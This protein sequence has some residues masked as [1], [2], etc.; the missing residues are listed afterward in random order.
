MLQQTTV[1]AVIPYFERFLAR[2]PDVVS[3]AAAEQHEVLA[4]WAGLG[5]YAR[6]RNL[7]ACARIVAALGGFPADIAGLRA[8]PGIG[9]YTASAVA[10]I[11]FG[12]PT[13]PVDG[14]VERVTARLFAV[15]EPLPGARPTLARLAATLGEDTDARAAPSDFAQ[16]LFDLGATICTPRRPTCALC[17]WREPCAG[18]RGGI[19]E[20]LPLKAAKMERP[21]RHGVHFWLEDRHGRVLLR[22]RPATGLFAGMTE[23]PGTAWR[24]EPWSEADALAAAPMPAPWRRVGAVLHT[25]T[26]LEVRL[27]LFAANVTAIEAEG[28]LRSATALEGEALPTIM[29]KCVAMAVARDE[30]C[31]NSGGGGSFL[32]PDAEGPQP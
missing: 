23:L 4:L 29:R 27:E 6:G 22:R 14:N 1:T 32:P 26:H 9:A 2:F 21:V 17:P 3:L 11:A 13:V 10:A 12:V 20:R 15:E 7:H 28:L 5:Y 25:L 16:A 8:L 24:P 31:G 30:R 18:R 19:A